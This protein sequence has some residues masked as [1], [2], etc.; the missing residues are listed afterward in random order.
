MK[1]CGKNK[2]EEIDK[3]IPG[4]P[5]LLVVVLESFLAVIFICKFFLLLLDLLSNGLF[6]TS[7]W[8]NV[9]CFFD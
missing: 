8:L 1:T 7:D 5:S 3:F 2:E 6:T 9:T 4:I